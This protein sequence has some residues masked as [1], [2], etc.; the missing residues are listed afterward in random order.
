[1]SI[2]TDAQA[3]SGVP[4]SGNTERLGALA[5]AGGNAATL[6]AVYRDELAQAAR[7]GTLSDARGAEIATGCQL[8]AAAASPSA[9]ALVAFER[10]LH[11]ARLA[12]ARWSNGKSERDSKVIALELLADEAAERLHV[13]LDAFAS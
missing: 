11:G 5:P 10:A 4:P 6:V 9:S 12:A 13:D 7:S 1:M 8:G 2:E 3:Y